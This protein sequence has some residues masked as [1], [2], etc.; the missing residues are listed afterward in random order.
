MQLR[1]DKVVN[2]HGA[3][4]IKSAVHANVVIEGGIVWL[5]DSNIVTGGQALSI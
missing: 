3:K 4:F 1:K 5:H 2:N